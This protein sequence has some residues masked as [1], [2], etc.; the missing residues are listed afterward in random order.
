MICFFLHVFKKSNQ[1]KNIGVKNIKRLYTIIDFFQFYLFSS[2]FILF[3]KKKKKKKKNNIK[4]IIKKNNYILIISKTIFFIFILHIYLEQILYKPNN[5]H[6]WT[7]LD[8]SLTIPFTS[9]NDDYCD[10][11][12]G[13]DEP[14]IVSL[15]KIERKKD[16]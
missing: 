4:I 5:Q 6:Q 13:S 15:I 9:V 12:D 7:C 3:Q 1:E 14:G 16:K 8:G 2:S 10:C 11:L